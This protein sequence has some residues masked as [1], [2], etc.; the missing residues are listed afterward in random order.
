M[1]DE[2]ILQDELIRDEELENV[3]G[4]NRNE[5][6]NDGRALYNRGLLNWS[7]FQ[8]PTLVRELLHKMGY[9]YVDYDG[10]FKSFGAK[11]NEYYNKQGE[12]ISRKEF[13]ENFDAENSTKI[14]R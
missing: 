8:N 4:G 10:Y 7:E 6:F 12:K 9:K 14:I 13:W 11:D 1:K 3:V 5:T 2:K